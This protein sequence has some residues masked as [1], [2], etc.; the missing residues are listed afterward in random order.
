MGKGAKIR[1]MRAEGTNRRNIL[2]SK[3][4]KPHQMKNPAN[5]EKAIRLA[6]SN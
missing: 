6:T 5:A 3:A 1:K 2:V 4:K